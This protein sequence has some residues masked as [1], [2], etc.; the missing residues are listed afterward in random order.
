VKDVRDELSELAF[1]AGWSAVRALPERAARTLFD[2]FADQAWVRHGRSVQQLERNLRR[3]VPD[4]STRELRELSRAAARSYL[5][6]WCEVFRLPDWSP[7]RV[8]HGIRVDDQKYMTEAL[9]QGGAVMSL[10][11]M[12]N[13]DHAGAWA[14]LEYGG[15]TTV[16]E[17]LRPEGL[18]E[19]FLAYREGLGMEVLPLTGGGGPFR[20]LLERARSGRLICLLGDRDLTTNGVTVSFFGEPAT[21]PGGP[22]ALSIASGTPLLPVTLWYEEGLTCFRIHPPLRPPDTGTRAEKVAAMTQA[23]AD[24]FAGGIAQHP[25]DWH[26]MQ[27]LWVADVPARNGGGQP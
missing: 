27:R 15:L 11:H 5:R 18:Y 2:L 14:C 24:L 16:A 3:V 8:V 9:E 12:A 13:W 17:R 20:T 7:E 26:M 1:A 25:Q 10:P 21:M 23:C 22:A 19:R 4:A 6:Y